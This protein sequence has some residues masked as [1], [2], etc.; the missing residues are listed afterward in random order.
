MKIYKLTQI[1]ST[2]YDTC[3]GMIVIAASESIAREMHPFNYQKSHYPYNFASTV[4]E[5]SPWGWAKIPENVIVEYLG[6]AREFDY[7][8][9]VMVS[10]IKG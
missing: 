4:W 7:C 10:F 5:N 2:G 8:R 9:I 3:S 6:E 1:D